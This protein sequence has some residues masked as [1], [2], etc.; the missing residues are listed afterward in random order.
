MTSKA[1]STTNAITASAFFV[2]ALVAD[3]LTA[4]EVE[5]DVPASLR[6]TCLALVALFASPVIIRPEKGVYGWVQRP[7]IG[8]LLFVMSLVGLHEGGAMTRAFD[9]FFLTIVCMAVIGLYSLGGVDE[10]SKEAGA[11][12][13]QEMAVS[14]SSCMLAGSLMLYS[15]LRIMRAGFRH[16]MEVRNFGV[17]M[18]N[19]TQFARGYAHA[20]DVATVSVVFGGSLGIGAALVMVAN[21]KQLAKG[22]GAI[23]LQ[24]A[25]AG[26]YQLLAAFA[27]SLSTGS[28]VTHLPALF[29]DGACAGMSGACKAAAMSRRF[30]TTNTASAGLWL[31]AIGMFALA[32]PPTIRL[33]SR[34]DAARFQWSI[35]GFVFSLFAGVI[36]FLLIWSN[37]NFQHH[38]DYVMLLSLVSILWSSFLDTWSGP[39][40][41]LAAFIW[42]EFVYV[43]EF[44]V[45]RALTQITHVF[46]YFN[47]TMLILH[48]AFVALN[49]VFPTRFIELATGAIAVFGTSVATGLFTTSACLN[50]GY[51][52]QIDASYRVYNGPKDAASFTFQHFIPVIVWAPIY[53]CRCEVNLLSKTARATTWMLTTPLVVGAYAAAVAILATTPPVTT[54]FDDWALS[55]SIVGAGLLPWAAAS[56]V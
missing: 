33:T 27:A 1:G 30:S 21:V 49:R 15:N 29:A 11:G 51:G 44:G 42:D 50:M 2:G 28:Q 46:L 48:A 35:S 18:Q 10:V 43:A 41:Y 4:R 54:F 22:S 6:G 39:F 16:P 40:F 34:A 31:S 45:E 56:I 25:S 24:L 38:I 20:S 47:A 13:T 8:T 5:T 3:A 12:S 36:A 53:T 7:I 37:S 55:G 14:T 19:S 26:V 17:P 9:S 52:G 32:Y 23:S